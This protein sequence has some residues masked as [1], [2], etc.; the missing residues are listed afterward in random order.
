MSGGHHIP[1]DTIRRRY[2]AGSNNL[3]KLYLPICDYWMIINNS[4]DPFQKV[5]DGNK[6][7]VLNILDKELYTKIVK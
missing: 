4:I 7:S 3:A 1:E 2:D 5:A 6:L